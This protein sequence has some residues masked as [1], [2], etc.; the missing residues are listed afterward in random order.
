M[1]LTK[2]ALLAAVGALFLA[3]L[4]ATAGAARGMEIAVQD[5]GVFTGPAK[6]AH[7][8]IVAAAHIKSTYVRV[9]L[10]WA[11]IAGSHA[12]SRKTPK[13]PHY[14][15]G[16]Y[17]GVVFLASR[18]HMQVQFVLTGP[19]PAWAAANHRKG[20]FAP[21]SGYFAEYARQAAVW[22][23]GRVHRWSIWNEPNFSSWLQPQRRAAGIYR[24]LYTRGYASIKGVDPTNTVLI[25]ETSP[26]SERR[27]AI[28]PLKFLRDVL[29]VN[30]AWQLKRHCAGLVADGY[31][32]HPYDFR[33]A[34]NY[35]YPGADNV[36]MG[37]LGRLTSALSQAQRTGALRTPSGGML[38]VYL[39]EYGYLSSGH[40]RISD[41]K[42]AKYIVQGFN[43]ALKNPFVREVVQY[44]LLPPKGRYRFFDMSILT[45]RGKARRPYKALQKWVN[46]MA[47]RGMIALP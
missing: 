24:A 29:C 3:P 5:D 14:N 35:R 38:P 27:I 7:K 9:F 6:A 46:T 44:T 22:F 31:A 1:R 47:A 40:G 21:K 36:T 2:L 25:G 11:D 20:V 8:A 42:Y 43:I 30:H 17:D 23:R 32:Q 10:P 37:T 45:S 16:G 15:F 28:S 26:Y 18:Y 34:P 19:V 39:T 4:A 13:H 41:R 12:N 33:H